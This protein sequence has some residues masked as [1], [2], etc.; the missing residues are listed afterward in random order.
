[1]RKQPTPLKRYY[2]I[3]SAKISMFDQQRKT[4]SIWQRL[5]HYLASITKVQI[6][7]VNLERAPGVN[8]PETD[9]PK[10][11]RVLTEIERKHKIG[12]VDEPAEYIKDTLPLFTQLI[13]SRPGTYNRSED[14]PGLV[15]FGGGTA[16]TAIALIG[17]PF[18]LSGR[19]RDPSEEPSS[20]LPDLVAYLNKRFGEIIPGRTR[21]QDSGI[22]IVEVIDRH[23]KE[24]R[25]PMEFFAWRILDSAHIKGFHPHKRLLLY[26]PI[27]VAYASDSSTPY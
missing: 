18:H 14:D 8:S 27:Y 16:K 1:M 25:I 6:W 20:D 4:N 10:M 12:T 7:Q 19:V 17:S 24:P 2:Y 11:A 26:S 22:T 15:Y 9:I 23:H 5:L 21:K 13:P 3:S